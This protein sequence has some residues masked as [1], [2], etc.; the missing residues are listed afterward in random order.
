MT[1]GCF[2]A[3][4]ETYLHKPKGIKKVSN[5]FS[6]AKIFYNSIRLRPSFKPKL[7]NSSCTIYILSVKSKVG[8]IIKRPLTLLVELL[9]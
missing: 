8:V 3:H 9:K 4:I 5:P 7:N 2:P 6:Q 1:Q